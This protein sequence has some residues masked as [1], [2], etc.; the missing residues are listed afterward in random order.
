MTLLRAILVSFI[1]HCSSIG[2]VLIAF[3]LLLASGSTFSCL[4]YSVG[5][6]DDGDKPLG[7][8]AIKALLMPAV[9][10]FDR[11]ILNCFNPLKLNGN[12]M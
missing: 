10:P 4:G 8:V 9:F 3:T 5:F 11:G 7:S 2:L 1:G 6:R 12:Y